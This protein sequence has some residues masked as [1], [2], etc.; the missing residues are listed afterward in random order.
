VI[1]ASETAAASDVEPD[2]EVGGLACSS[3]DSHAEVAEAVEQREGAEPRKRGGEGDV[4]D[5]AV[6]SDVDGLW[7]TGRS[8]RVKNDSGPLRLLFWRQSCWVRRDLGLPNPSRTPEREPLLSNKLDF[9]SLL[10]ELFLRLLSDGCVLGP[11]YEVGRLGQTTQVRNGGDRVVDGQKDRG[12][13]ELGE[14]DLEECLVDGRG[15]EHGNDL[16]WRDFAGCAGRLQTQVG[17]VRC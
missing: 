2:Q 11:I 5:E 17:V 9:E 16:F 1:D 14:S 10:R 6:V 7:E 3:A 4:G 13:P 12:E 8:R 15:G